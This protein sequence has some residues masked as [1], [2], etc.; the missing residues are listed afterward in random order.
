MG[1]RDHER[2]EIFEHLKRGRDP[3]ECSKREDIVKSLG[4]SVEHL[5][6]KKRMILDEVV[7]LDRQSDEKNMERRRL[8]S[9]KC[10]PCEGRID[11]RARG[12][13]TDHFV[14][15]KLSSPRRH[16]DQPSA[17]HTA[18]PGHSS[19][20]AG[21]CLLAGTRQYQVRNVPAVRA[22]NEGEPDQHFQGSVPGKC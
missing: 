13:G 3:C 15:P 10:E 16:A 2:V 20:A 5:Q 22:W 9:T 14:I 7:Q 1:E 11:K 19:I 6:L 12:D 8:L 18:E 21:D 17:R 4:A